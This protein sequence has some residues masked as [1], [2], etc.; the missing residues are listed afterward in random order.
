MKLFSEDYAKTDEHIAGLLAENRLEAAEQ[1]LHKLKG[2]AGNLGAQELHRASEK[3]DAELKQGEYQ[4]E[5]LTA[6]R[7]SFEKTFATIDRLSAQD[8][9][10][11]PLAAPD[12]TLQTLA[13]E[14]D[15]LLAQHDFVPLELLDQ[16]QQLVPNDRQDQLPQL[17]HLIEIIDYPA[18]RTALHSLLTP[19]E[20]N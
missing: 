11:A 1:Q 17:L 4:T 16:L 5:T 18:A 19:N 13:L 3:L 6:W 20:E 8:F 9:A 7:N 14:L 15:N 10:P 12:V 2:I